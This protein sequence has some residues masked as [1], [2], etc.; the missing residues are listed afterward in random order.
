MRDV[1]RIY[2]FGRGLNWKGPLRSLFPWDFVVN[3]ALI[4][5]FKR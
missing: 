5:L 2:P 3:E 1:E 4:L